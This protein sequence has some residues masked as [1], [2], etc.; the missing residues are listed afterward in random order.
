ML[1]FFFD[2]V[3][4]ASVK[5]PAA[6]FVD[7]SEHWRLFCTIRLRR[8]TMA[9]VLCVTL[10]VR[11]ERVR[12]AERVGYLKEKGQSGSKKLNRSSIRSKRVSNADSRVVQRLR[13]RN[14][15]EGGRAWDANNPNDDGCSAS[16]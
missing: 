9:R 3:I 15:L 2:S 1:L 5:R 6:A 4:P 8:L 12:Q 10:L 13:P 16:K 7:S 11:G 14:P